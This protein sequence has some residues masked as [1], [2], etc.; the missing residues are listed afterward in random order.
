MRRVLVLVMIVALLLVPDLASGA[1]PQPYEVTLKPTGN[2][3]MDSALHD[4]SQLELLREKAPV[5]PFALVTR[6]RADVGRFQQALQSF[7][8]YKGTVSLTIDG[9]PLDQA[10]LPDLLEHAPDKPPVPVVASFDPGPLF[11]LGKVAV[12]GDVPE[13]ARQS[14]GLAPGAPAV[15]ADVLTAQQRLLAAIRAAGHPL[16]KVDL[17]PVTLVLARDEIDVAFEVS[18]GPVRGYRAD[19]RHGFEDG[20]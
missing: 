10:D 4:T 13:A 3:A 7:G 12:E 18:A 9:H 11:H 2:A 16:A 8:Y 15:A 5:G 6:A 17:P 1:D 14:L 20:E 19:H